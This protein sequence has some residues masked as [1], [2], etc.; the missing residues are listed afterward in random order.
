MALPQKRWYWMIIFERRYEP[1]L[2]G[3]LDGFA[4]RR[5]ADGYPDTKSGHTENQKERHPGR[6]RRLVV[7][8]VGN[9]SIP[10]APSSVG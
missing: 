5:H 4:R 1:I 7:G 6:I 2:E 8:E 9:V 10:P 3:A